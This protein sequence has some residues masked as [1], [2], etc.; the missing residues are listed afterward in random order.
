M[1]N[2]FKALWQ[3]ILAVRRR[4][5]KAVV[6]LY[7][8]HLF[9]TERKKADRRH[10]KHGIMF[11]VASRPFN[12][13]ELTI[14]DKKRFKAEKHIFGYHAR[15]LTL[16]TMKAR[17]FYHTPDRAGNQ[18]MPEKEVQFRRSAFIHDRLKAAK[19]L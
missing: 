5:A 12:P 10:K 18:A 19:L 9:D 17:C 3:G 7:A 4:L 11:Y 14:Y 6:T 13:R 1:T 8:K 16:Q 15:L 2:P